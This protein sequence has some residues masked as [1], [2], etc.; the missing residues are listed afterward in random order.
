M[1]EFEP[2]QMKNQDLLRVRLQ[3]QQGSPLLRQLGCLLQR[4][5]QLLNHHQVEVLLEVEQAQVEAEQVLVEKV[6]V[7]AQD[8]KQETAIRFLPLIQLR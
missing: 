8:L 3:C 1:V 2:L 5:V 4:L 7:L 6:R